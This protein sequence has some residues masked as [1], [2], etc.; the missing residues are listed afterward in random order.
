MLP[1]IFSLFFDDIL[2]VVDRKIVTI[3]NLVAYLI[4]N[5][6]QYLRNHRYATDPQYLKQNGCLNLY[7][8]PSFG[9]PRVAPIA[10][11]FVEH[12]K[13]TTCTKIVPVDLLQADKGYLYLV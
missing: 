1:G 13:L 4:N 7:K 11:A 12:L 10:C 8:T 2:E 5:Y 9:I 3:C 6:I